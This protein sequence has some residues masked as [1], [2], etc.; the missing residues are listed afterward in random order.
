[1]LLALCLASSL[2]A[3]DPAPAPVDRIVLAT[4]A[5]TMAQAQ[6][7]AGTGPI[8]RPMMWSRRLF[9]LQR[10]AGNASASVDLMFRAKEIE[11]IA[12]SLLK[13]GSTTELDVLE[14]TW[15]R[16]EAERAVKR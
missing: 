1:M 13:A 7:R 9:D 11:A 8:E 16:T 12:R 6:Y 10:E 3:A 15:Q 4:K 5:F 14:A 2:L